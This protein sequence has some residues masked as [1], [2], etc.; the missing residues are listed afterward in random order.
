MK[1]SVTL[2]L[3]GVSAFPVEERTMAFE[4]REGALLREVVELI[5]NRNP[6]FKENFVTP[7]GDFV[8]RIVVLI[9]GLNASSS[10]GAYA[11]LCSGDEVNIIPAL[12]GG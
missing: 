1:V 6:G 8:R 7:S 4:L 12:A 5:D 10:G 2:N 9:N 11:V 3:L